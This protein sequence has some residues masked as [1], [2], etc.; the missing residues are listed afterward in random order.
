MWVLNSFPISCGFFAFCCVFF[1][2]QP[3]FFLFPHHEVLKDLVVLVLFLGGE[4]AEKV[5]VEGSLVQR[6][7]TETRTR[8]VLKDLNHAFSD[9]LLGSPRIPQRWLWVGFQGHRDRE[10]PGLKHTRNYS[11]SIFFFLFFLPVLYAI[12]YSKRI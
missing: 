9:Y 8:N 2:P 5:L 3:V 6:Y 7:Q 11:G 12:S 10:N 4:K 1:S